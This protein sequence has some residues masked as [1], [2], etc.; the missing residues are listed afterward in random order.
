MSWDSPI[1]SD[2]DVVGYSVRWSLNGE[3]QEEIDVPSKNTS[4]IFT[5]LQPGQNLSADVRTVSRR[6]DSELLNYVS[7][8]SKEVS[9]IT[10]ALEEGFTN[11]QEGQA[12]KCPP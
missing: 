3:P 9:V 4:Y 2:G 8:P 6:R 11:P 12:D 7:G 1:E 5:S 10:P